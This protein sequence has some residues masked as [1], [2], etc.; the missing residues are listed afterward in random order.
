MLFVPFWSVNIK[1]DFLSLFF[2]LK[3]KTG[4]SHQ[5]SSEIECSHTL[6]MRTFSGVWFTKVSVVKFEI[7]YIGIYIKMDTFWNLPFS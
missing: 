7:R 1:R 3:K 2:K 6:R 5:K 4:W